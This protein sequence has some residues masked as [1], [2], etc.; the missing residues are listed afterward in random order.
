MIRLL[1]ILATVFL[2]QNSQGQKVHWRGENSCG[3]YNE[4]GLLKEWPEE[5]PK[6]ILATEGI[7]AGWGSVIMCENIMYAVGKRDSMDYMSAITMNGDILWQKVIGKGWSRSFPAARSTP[8]FDDGRLYAMSG[9]GRMACID[10]KSGDEIWGLNVDSTYNTNWH[11]WGVA[12]SPMILDD[13]VI[14]VPAGE[15]TAMVALNKYTGEEMW[16]TESLGGQRSYVT[17]VLLEYE[18]LIQIIGVTANDILA[19]HPGTG[20]ILWVY[21]LSEKIAEIRDEEHKAYIL[22]NSPL[23]KD[24]NVYVSGGYD[25]ISIMLEVAEDGNSVKEKW[26]DR[27]LDNHHHGLVLIDDYIYGS[28]WYSNRHGRWVCMSWETGE[29]KYVEEWNSKGVTVSADG[30]L[31]LYAEKSGLLGL[32]KP[33][34]DGFDLISSFKLEEGKGQHWAHPFIKD[35]KMFMRHG[36]ALVVFDIRE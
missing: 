29:V 11:H 15:T 31:Y 1:L 23:I 18:D 34:K 30:M 14:T 7:G 35:G 3:I 6:K 17:P 22:A 10:A 32:A 13:M 19:V 25:N 26:I 9:S 4:T 12:E 5:G 24:R 27:T 21:K 20:E 36:D 28:N 33:D 2:V 16:K 8:T